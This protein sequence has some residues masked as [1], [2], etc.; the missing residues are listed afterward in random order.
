MR[1]PKVVDLW[2]VVLTVICFVPFIQGGCGGGGGSSSPAPRTMAEVNASTAADSLE[3]LE[4]VTSIEQGILDGSDATVGALST[5]LAQPTMFKKIRGLIDKV[6]DE[7]RIGSVHALGSLPASPPTPCT[8]G[9]TESISM[10]WSGPDNPLDCTQMS[11]LSMTLT[12]VNCSELGVTM[13]GTMTVTLPGSS[14][15]L[16]AGDPTRMTMVMDM[17]IDDGVSV[18]DFNNLSMGISELVYDPYYEITDMTVRLDGTITEDQESV[19]F[20][21]FDL[22]WTFDAL[23]AE[24]LIS[25]DGYIECPCVQGWLQIT[26]LESIVFPLGVTCPVSGL[27]TITGSDGDATIRINGNTSVDILMDGNVIQTYPSCTV[28]HACLG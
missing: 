2:I 21:D 22:G 16:L 28:N 20:D 10:T 4:S 3:V 24:Y 19:S 14:C 26:T 15:D 9:G 1:N 23:N 8:E 12:M 7:T 6:A 25:M 11:N 18:V 27:Y 5:G 17:T 13:N